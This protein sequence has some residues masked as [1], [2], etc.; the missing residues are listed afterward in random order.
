MAGFLS[1]FQRRRIQ[2]RRSKHELRATASALKVDRT[3]RAIFLE[4]QAIGQ[5]TLGLLS[6]I[7]QS[8]ANILCPYLEDNSLFV[9]KEKLP[10]VSL[11]LE[12]SSGTIEIQQ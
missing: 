12:E 6:R 10:A 7:W 4:D 11:S 8:V 5:T 3:T 2:E 1:H 9:A